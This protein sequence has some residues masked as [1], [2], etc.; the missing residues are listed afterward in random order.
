MILE[1]PP[2][3]WR[4]LP[5]VILNAP[6]RGNTSTDVEKTL[7]VYGPSELTRKHLHR[8]GED[9]DA[10]D[11]SPKVLRNTSTDVEKT[12]TIYS[13]SIPDWKHLHGR[14]EDANKR[15]GANIAV[16]TPPRT[17]R[18]RRHLVVGKK[19]TGN[20]STDVEKTRISA[21]APTEFW[22]HLHGRGEDPAQGLCRSAQDRNTSTDVEKTQY[23]QQ[24]H[25]QTRKHL[26][27]RGEDQKLKSP[28]RL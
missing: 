3:T 18:R 10:G 11:R 7:A 9:C 24:L 13:L 14:G 20:T 25:K 5:T 12:T 19:A 27:G 2:R 23:Q 28:L 15:K 8:R 22:K 17:W 26:H 1:T 21:L 16:E 4:R 6:A